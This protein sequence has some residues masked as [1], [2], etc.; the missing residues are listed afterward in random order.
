MLINLLQNDES[1]QV[2]VIDKESI[3]FKSYINN[4]NT[5]NT[6][7]SFTANDELYSTWI[8][9]GVSLE[10]HIWVSMEYK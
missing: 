4:D 7:A 9:N 1:I 8:K 5:I 10:N 3:H 2:I 6:L